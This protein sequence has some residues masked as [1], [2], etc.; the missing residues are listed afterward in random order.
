M[1]WSGIAALSRQFSK[2]LGVGAVATSAQYIALLVLVQSFGVWATVASDIGLLLGALV[3][4]L[5]NRRFTFNST[6]AHSRAIAKF[7]IVASV[8]LLLN[9]LIFAAALNLGLH[10]LLAQVAATGIV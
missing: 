3:S 6:L 9:T 4:Y 1:N 2:F 8:G 7:A 10:Y 5:L